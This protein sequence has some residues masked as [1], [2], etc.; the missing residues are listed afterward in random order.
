MLS[1]LYI[2]K[3]VHNTNVLLVLTTAGYFLPIGNLSN[4]MFLAFKY[5]KNIPVVCDLPK[6]TLK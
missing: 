6:G 4:R 1:A 3:D 2:Q 5:K